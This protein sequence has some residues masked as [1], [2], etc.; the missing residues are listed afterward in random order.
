MLENRIRM[1]VEVVTVRTVIPDDMPV[2]CVF[3]DWAAGGWDRLSVDLA[4]V[5]K[6]HGV[7][8]VDVSTGGLIRPRRPFRSSQATMCR[9]PSRFASRADVPVTAAVGLITK[10]KQA[11]KVPKAGQGMPSKSDVRHAGSI[12]SRYARRTG[13]ACRSRKRRILAQYVRGAFR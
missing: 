1:L 5:L 12:L 8:L 10:P 4:K 7:D 6:E 13:R 9:S 2:L 11:E 3:T